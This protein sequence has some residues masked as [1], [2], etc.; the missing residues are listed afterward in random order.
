MDIKKM[1]SAKKT[2]T[3]AT[4]LIDEQERLEPA[5]HTEAALRRLTSRLNNAEE[6]YES[7]YKSLED[8]TEVEYEAY[9]DFQSSVEDQRARVEHVKLMHTAYA[10]AED[11]LELLEYWEGLSTEDLWVKAEREIDSLQT[12][13][14][15][16][17]ELTRPRKLASSPQIKSLVNDMRKRF[18]H[19]KKEA[20]PAASSSDSSAAAHC[21]EDTGSSMRQGIKPRTLPL[22]VYSGEL[23]D[24]HFFWRRF[25]D[26]LDRMPRLTTDEML[27]FLLECIRDQSACNII[28]DALQNGDSFEFA[29]KRLAVTF[30]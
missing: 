22:P 17:V 14:D 4:G 5:K 29:E 9:A 16:F 24:W 8:P 12:Q 30:D 3:R 23:A 20:T 25:L 6:S 19:L 28:K 2:V 11:L 26:Y 21:D 13:F 1:S 10:E 15:K 18:D 27:I 7:A